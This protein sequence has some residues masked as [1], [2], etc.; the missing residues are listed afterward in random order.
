[1]DWRESAGSATSRPGASA[2]LSFFLLAFVCLQL[3]EFI[4]LSYEALLF[5]MG[6]GAYFMLIV[7]QCLLFVFPTLLYYRRR[8]ALRPAL[9]MQRPD[10]LSVLLIVPAALLGIV[11]LNGLTTYWVM[12][13]Q[14]LGL[15]PSA[16]TMAVPQTPGGLVWMLLT[17]SLV[18]AFCEELLFRGMLLPSLEPHGKR[19]AIL[20]TGALFALPHARP[21][22]LPAHL[23]LGVFLSWAVLESDCL[24]LAMICHGVYNAAI[25]LLAYLQ[26]PGVE[27]AAA[28]ALPTAAEA[29]SMLPFVVLL[30][31]GAAMLA[32]A[33]VWRA[34]K[35]R[36]Q[37]LP[38]ATRRKMPPL[39]RKLFALSWVSVAL[40]I[41]F[42]VWRTLPGNAA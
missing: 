24:P 5:H 4:A 32:Y 19:F 17:S 40:L 13:L 15:P 1:M 26:G 29:L 34:R 31:A 30:G 11:A 7:A 12:L 42:S 6:L 33:A 41:A 10:A 36:A 16:E 38:P 14:K 37:A 2:G 35:A 25:I 8:P 9:R 20:C 39:A 3:L 18:P 22:A 21:E 27:D 28:Q 23:L